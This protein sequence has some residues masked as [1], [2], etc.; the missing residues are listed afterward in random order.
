MRVHDVV[1]RRVERV[2][3]GTEEPSESPVAREEGD[4]RRRRQLRDEVG[5][6]RD[7]SLAHEREAMLVVLPVRLA[8]DDDQVEDAHLPFGARYRATS[9]P[10]NDA[11]RTFS[12]ICAA[13]VVLGV[14]PN[15]LRSAHPLHRSED[16]PRTLD[17][18]GR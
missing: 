5:D 6:D 2:L 13:V 3:Q 8:E 16:A 18:S 15:E 10:L 9:V 1:L 14:E 7:V 17:D 4:L 12:A 11:V